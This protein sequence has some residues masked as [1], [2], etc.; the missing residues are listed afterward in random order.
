MTD[1]KALFKASKEINF[2]LYNMRTLIVYKLLINK[3][4]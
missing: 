3:V 4:R 2:Q 1:L